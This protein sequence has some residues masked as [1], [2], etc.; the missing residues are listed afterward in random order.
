MGLPLVPLGG[1]GR[2]PQV[3]DRDRSPSRF[4]CRECNL[5]PLVLGAPWCH[6]LGLG[7]LRGRG[8][9]PGS[10]KFSP[11]SDLFWFFAFM[12]HFSIESL[13]LFACSR[14]RVSLLDKAAQIIA[15]LSSSLLYPSSPPHLPFG[16]R[17]IF[18]KS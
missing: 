15:T 6:S 2:G 10:G 4:G 18:K 3:C 7:V 16:H 14:D 12:G 9:H 13:S 1:T 17:M 11:R 5:W 8:H